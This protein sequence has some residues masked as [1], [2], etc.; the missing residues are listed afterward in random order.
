MMIRDELWAWIRKLEV[1]CRLSCTYLVRQP[2]QIARKRRRD[3]GI[4]Y[5]LSRWHR[6]GRLARH[7]IKPFTAYYLPSGKPGI[8]GNLAH[9]L[10]AGLAAAKLYADLKG[11]TQVELLRQPCGDRLPDWTLTADPGARYRYFLEFHSAGNPARELAATVAGYEGQLGEGDFV[12]IV[13]Q[14]PIPLSLPSEQFM[15]VTLQD[16][17]SASDSWRAPIWRWGEHDGRHS[18]VES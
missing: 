12:L 15:Y 8:R 7:A 3:Q 11:R 14:L 16:H 17:L 13:S 5:H 1:V 18:L 2:A 4:E 9:D 6:Q 10:L